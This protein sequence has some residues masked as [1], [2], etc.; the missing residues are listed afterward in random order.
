MRPASGKL[1]ATLS[2]LGGL[3]LLFLLLPNLWQS[4]VKVVYHLIGID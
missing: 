3:A 4:L 1:L 2:V